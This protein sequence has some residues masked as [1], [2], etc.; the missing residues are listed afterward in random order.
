MTFVYTFDP[1]EIHQQEEL[2]FNPF[3]SILDFPLGE[4]EDFNSPYNVQER[5]KF[6]HGFNE[7]S[8][9][10]ISTFNTNKRVKVSENDDVISRC[11]GD[12]TNDYTNPQN[13]YEN[14]VD[15]H[16]TTDRKLSIEQ[17]QT[18]GIAKSENLQECVNRREAKNE[19]KQ[20]QPSRRRKRKGI[21]RRDQYRKRK[22]VLMKGVLRKCRKYF[23]EKYTIF[24]RAQYLETL[25][26][27]PVGQNEQSESFLEEGVF[28]IDQEVLEA[29]CQQEF[30]PKAPKYIMYYLGK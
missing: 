12:F 4:Y 15:C 2:D 6:N 17:A 7:Y 27:D 18:A 10:V 14:L 16:K 25:Q 28:E 30:G 9:R 13:G 8:I 20:T 1:E 24:A 3:N 29:F 23:Q 22:D 19:S 11:N 26:K 5:P 21:V